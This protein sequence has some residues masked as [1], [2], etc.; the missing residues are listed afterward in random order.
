MTGRY[1]LEETADEINWKDRD[2]YKSGLTA[3]AQSA[4]NELPQA[5]IYYLSLEIGDDISGDI[6]GHEIVRYTNTESSSLDEIYFR[7]FPNFQGGILTVTNLTVDGAEPKTQLESGF[8][9]VQVSLPEPLEPGASADISYTSLEIADD[10]EE[11]IQSQEIVNYFN[12]ESEPIEEI[13][14]LL[15]PNYEDGAVTVT[16]LQVDGV[17]ANI[18]QEDLFTALRIDLPEPLKPGESIVFEMDFSLG[19]PTEMGGNY[20]LFGYFE[21]VLVLDTFY[22]LIPA[23]DENGW[24]K[25]FPQPNGDHSYQDASFYV[26][27]VQAPADMKLASSGVAVNHQE[28]EGRQTVVFAAGPARDFYLA[29]SQKYVE[30][31]EQ[32][33]D[34][35]VKVFAKEEYSLHQGYA[36]EYALKAIEIL[37]E[38]VGDYPYT[39]FEVVSSPMRALGIEYP[40][41]T[42]IVVDEFIPGELYGVPSEVYLEST[43]AHE[44]GHMWFYNAIGNDQQ[45][46]P[47]VDE[48]LVQYM[49]YIYYLDNYGSGEGYANSWYGRWQ[50]VEFAE[51][52]I[53]MPA[54]KYYSEE[55]GGMAYGAIVYGRGPI[56]FL[57]LEQ[58]YGLETVLAAIEDYYATHLWGIAGAEDLRAALEGACD[59]DLSVEFEEWVYEN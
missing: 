26:V 57:A 12:S 29:G 45:N 51:I 42:S 6:D 5:S 52:P 2:V 39:E 34:L 8:T 49:T 47:W 44:V 17:E 7:L 18:S 13:S 56:F 1:C 53:G 19:I 22:P 32:V 36:L 38:R 11:D 30:L 46:E 16:E 15:F 48:A 41:I 20:G 35:T 4:L 27:Q 31:S 14:F 43:L 25:S 23:Y 9:T 33:G 55:T 40:G 24:Y 50:R 3:D 28:E 21:D 59:C 54:G 37:S 10:I 58:E